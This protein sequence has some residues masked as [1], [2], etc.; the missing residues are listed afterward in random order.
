[1]PI[2]FRCSQC[3][4]LLRTGDDTAG[5]QAKCPS[6]GSIQAI[7]M[8]SQG[9]APAPGAFPPLPSGLPDPFQSQP[10]SSAASDPFGAAPLPSGFDPNPYA[11][12]TVGAAPFEFRDRSGPRTGPPWERDR[13]SINSFF[14]TLRDFYAS[15]A[16]FFVNMRRE[17][18]VGV[19]FGFGMLGGCIALVFVIG[20]AVLM[21][22]LGF[23][24]QMQQP[25]FANQ[26]FD[27]RMAGLMGGCCWMI[28]GPLLVAAYLFT[29]AAVYHLLLLV[30][31]GAP[32]P[33]E[34]TFRVVAYSFG[35]LWPFAAVPLCGQYIVAVVHIV[36]L[37][38]GIW[39]AQE[40]SGLKAT[41]VV[42][43]PWLLCCGAFMGLIFFAIGSLIK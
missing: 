37:I 4:K 35:T 41:A 8:S 43:I 1:M 3:G 17:G 25:P 28:L 36:Y 5:K 21:Q 15:G 39:K 20:Y 38:I 29:A 31:G 16:S 18:G 24:V 30:F 26:P 22:M 40:V 19:P 6:C 34:T 33:Y 13:P 27:P 10:T 9:A 14:A 7:P 12:P 11:S 2:E 42:L 23:A 32:Q